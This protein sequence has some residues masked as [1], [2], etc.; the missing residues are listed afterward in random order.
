MQRPGPWGT[1]EEQ[2]SPCHPSAHCCLCGGSGPENGH[3]TQ[4]DMSGETQEPAGTWEKLPQFSWGGG[5]ER[6]WGVTST[7]PGG[8]NQKHTVEE[9]HGRQ[10]AL[11]RASGWWVGAAPSSQ[12]L[13]GRAAQGKEWGSR[14]CEGWAPWRGGAPLLHLL[15][16]HPP[17]NPGSK[18]PVISRCQQLYLGLCGCSGSAW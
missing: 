9:V 16:T 15:A 11:R 12:M 1:G 17:G 6:L 10:G 14:G 13:L 5:Q 8:A 7:G 4:S 3:A 2:A 18:G